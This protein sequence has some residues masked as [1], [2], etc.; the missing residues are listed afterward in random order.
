LA[1]DRR[2]RRSLGRP[3]GQAGKHVS[4][5]GRVLLLLVAASCGGQKTAPPQ[6][7]ALGGDSVARVGQELLAARLVGE[8]A[9]RQRIPV[10]DALG[11]LIDDCLIEELAR[12]QGLDTLP[13]VR[14]ELDAARA[15]LVLDHT[16]AAARAA[17]PPTDAEVEELTKLHWREVD[18]PDQMRVVHVV[19]LRPKP[20]DSTKDSAGRALAGQL[21][22]AVVAAADAADFEA[23]AKA[24]P[25]PGFDVRVERVEPFV[26]DGRILTKAGTYDTAFAAASAALASPGSTSGVVESSF[27]W[28]IIRLMERTPGVHMSLE[29]RRLAFEEEVVSKRATTEVALLVGRLH[30]SVPIEVAN[31]ADDLLTEA[32]A[33]LELVASADGERP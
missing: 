14:R 30:K 24:V 29:D 7:V 8:V 18:L 32:F 10:R 6:S 28:H 4:G 11:A 27:G 33:R 20:S 25:H 22:A 5:T 1:G 21:G 12:E 3:A 26:A 2:G 9:A 19:V 13:V 15:R 31:G 16:G 17:G 23:R